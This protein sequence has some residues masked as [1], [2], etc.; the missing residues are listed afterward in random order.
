[1]NEPLLFAIRREIDLGLAAAARLQHEAAR[2]RAAGEAPDACSSAAAGDTPSPLPSPAPAA[3][4][5]HR[6]APAEVRAQYSLQ[7]KARAAV[8]R[9]ADR[10]ATSEAAAAAAGGRLAPQAAGAIAATCA[11]ACTSLS[12]SFVRICPIAVIGAGRQAWGR[13]AI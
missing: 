1:M 10:Q 7:V 13:R 5:H 8:M 2:R 4:R 11:I 9:I 6:A 12:R 3:P